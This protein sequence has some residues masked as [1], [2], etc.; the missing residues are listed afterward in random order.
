MGKAWRGAERMGAGVLTGLRLADFLFFCT[1]SCQKRAKWGLEET[2]KHQKS[3][4]SRE[5]TSTVEGK[6]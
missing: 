4:L 6:S 1:P 2:E 3:S 5:T